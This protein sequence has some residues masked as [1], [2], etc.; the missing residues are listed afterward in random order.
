M[1]L[2]S[3]VPP[4]AWG[5]ASA[6]VALAIAALRDRWFKRQ[7]SA[8]IADLR[9]QLAGIRVRMRRDRHG[10]AGYLTAV[11]LRLATTRRKVGLPPSDVDETPAPAPEQVPAFDEHEDAD[12]RL[13]LQLPEKPRS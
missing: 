10:L 1:P 5:A 13:A 8:E 12:E 9:R 11:N 7:E 4:G 2:F 3:D 6:V